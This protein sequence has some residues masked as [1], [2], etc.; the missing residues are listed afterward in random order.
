MKRLAAAAFLAAL[1][2]AVPSAADW[3]A[4]GPQMS[5]S[6]CR[7]PETPLF[8]CKVG[9]RVVSICAPPQSEQAQGERTPG[10]PARSGAVYRFG[11]PGHIELEL[12]G[13]HY[14]E[15]GFAGGGETQIHA[16]TPTHRYIVYDSIVR[17]GFGPDG[18]HY[19]QAASGLV[20]Q[21]GGKVV[22][23]RACTE[24]RTFSPLAE[25]LIPPGDYVPH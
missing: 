20:V 15:Q 7:V 13:L 19:P 12:T 14:A 2:A 1:A 6:L 24:A 11:R 5:G 22:S 4:G 16:D 21:S 3:T 25:K 23:N 8:S 18:L 9:T 10:E 17:T